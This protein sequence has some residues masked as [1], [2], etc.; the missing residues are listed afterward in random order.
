MRDTFILLS[1]KGI[2][3][4]ENIIF[5]DT[6]I[7][8]IKFK[9]R[10][11]RRYYCSAELEKTQN[12]SLLV[13]RLDPRRSLDMVGLLVRVPNVDDNLAYQI[14]QQNNSNSYL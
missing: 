8:I 11:K 3:I 6:I 2:S 12:F 1:I 13:M 10:G 7:P 14:K 5:A 9:L 4:Q